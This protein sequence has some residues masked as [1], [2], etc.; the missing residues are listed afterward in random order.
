MKNWVVYFNEILKTDLLDFKLN[1]LNTAIQSMS[2]IQRKFLLSIFSIYFKN[3]TYVQYKLDDIELT[4]IFKYINNA[5]TTSLDFK[6]M[7]SE[8]IC[9]KLMICK[10]FNS[11]KDIKHSEYFQD[12]LFLSSYC[13][14]KNEF[15]LYLDMFTGNLN[16]GLCKKHFIDAMHKSY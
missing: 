1:L 11:T 3:Q 8:G 14:S 15:C 7:S 16:I 9:L 10:Y 4:K 13:T 12:L 6:S 2:V 5:K